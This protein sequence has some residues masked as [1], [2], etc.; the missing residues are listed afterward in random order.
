LKVQSTLAAQA[1]LLCSELQGCLARVVTFL[2]RAEAAL[3]RPLVTPGV[4][5]PS[6]LHV[7]SHVES[8]D[9][10]KAELYGCFSPR[11]GLSISSLLD[12][13]MCEASAVMAH[14]L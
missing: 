1:E 13:S 4:S 8:I 2:V 7:G 12:A 3:G 6:E 5:S 11:V 9:E 14:V 10:G